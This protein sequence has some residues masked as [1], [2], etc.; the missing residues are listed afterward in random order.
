[1][2][3]FMKAWLY[4]LFFSLASFGP[5]AYAQLGPYQGKV[6]DAETKQPVEGAAVLAVWW[7]QS[8][9]IAHPVESVHDAL[10]TV[11]D[12]DGNFTIPGM[13]EAPVDPQAKLMEPSFTIFKPGYK[14]YGPRTLKPMSAFLPKDVIEGLSD[15]IYEKNG[16]MVVELRQLKTQR[17][18]K[19]NLIGVLP[20]ACDPR[21]PTQFCV[22]SAKYP[23]LL[24]LV[25]EER[26]N[27]GLKIRVP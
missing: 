17:E 26:L 21:D 1:M 5:L 19:E 16:K 7:L 23:N 10:E 11:T 15:N 14:T 8:P 12:L 27:L 20:I 3:Y 18:R 24:N 6:I 22:D 9:G 2:R 4:L 13:I 25:N